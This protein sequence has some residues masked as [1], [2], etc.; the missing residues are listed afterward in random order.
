M[1]I[2]LTI[3][4]NSSAT[5]TLNRF[6]SA[7]YL[8]M[9][10]HHILIDCGEGTQMQLR[11][12][13]IKKSKLHYIFISHVHGDHILGLPGLIFSMNLNS[14]LE[15]L[16]IFGPASLFEIL[17]MFL[18]HS[19]TRLRFDIV[20][21]ITDDSKREVIFENMLIKVTSF[22][23]YHRI[24]TT[25]FI[26]EEQSRLRKLN[27]EACERYHIPFTF[28]NDIKRG[29]DFISADGKTEISNEKLTYDSGLPIR[30]AY[31]SDTIYDKR[32]INEVRDVDWLYHESTFLHEKLERAIETK[33]TTAKQAGMVAKEANVK[34]LLIGHFSSRYEDLN[35]LLEE[36]KTEFPQ[37][38]IAEE[39]I[40]F[41]FE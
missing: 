10:D 7:Q 36:A 31:C 34:N 38:E 32:V 12:Y 16:H 17:D 21:H 9:L 19:D 5:P 41:V 11:K 39:G 30:Y 37:T 4:G 20:K 3:L 33:H 26:F 40:T 25:G 6:P 15:P 23:L 35:E 22:P 14:R 28:Y 18:K 13:K 8:N 27:I 29:K 2:E 1:S 24:P